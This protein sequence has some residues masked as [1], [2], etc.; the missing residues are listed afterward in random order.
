[1]DE[2]H[3]SGHRILEIFSTCLSAKFLPAP[4]DKTFNKLPTGC[5]PAH[6]LRSLTS[7]P[8]S[9]TTLFIYSIPYF[10]SNSHDTTP[11]FPSS[12]SSRR[13]RLF[14]LSSSRMSNFSR[15]NMDAKAIIVA[16]IPTKDKL[17]ALEEEGDSNNSRHAAD[18]GRLGMATFGGKSRDTHLKQRI[19]ESHC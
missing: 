16:R 13:D 2:S 17:V 11:R 14:P 10:R 18:N 6:S 19:K 4:P 7:M 3:G 8:V 12:S 5:T 15:V 9:I 1:M